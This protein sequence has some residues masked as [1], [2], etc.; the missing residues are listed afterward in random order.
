MKMK[1]ITLYSLTSF[2]PPF[3]FSLALFSFFVFLGIFIEK[4]SMLS[5]YSV[6][7]ATVFSL[8]FAQTPYIT[9]MTIPIASMSGAFFSFKKLMN[10]GE[11]KA[12]LAAGWSPFSMI[13]PLLKFSMIIAVFH[14]CFSEFV[15]APSYARYNKIYR[16]DFKKKPKE[17]SYIVESPVFKN[18]NVFFLASTYNAKA[19]TFFQLSGEKY[20]EDVP[21]YAIYASS[22]VYENGIWAL[23]DG[24][25]VEY[26]DSNVV[27][28]NHFEIKKYL[29]LP[30]PSDLV[31]SE[32]DLE[33][34]DFFSLSDRILKL[35]KLGLKRKKELIS[36]WTKLSSPISSFVMILAAAVAS[37]LPLIS[38]SMLGAG[39]SLFFGFLFWNLSLTFQ[40]MAEIET[41]SPFWG[42]FAAP[43]IF[44]VISIVLLK[45]MRVF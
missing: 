4:L 36:F 32:N 19:K 40:R 45:K 24:L 3:I 41:I 21:I 44:A 23:K 22:A 16:E 28:Q 26:N 12:F 31:F 7:F 37:M 13:S 39:V 20:F 42:A 11:W 27:A 43:I 15:A 8:A 35:K 18:G 6:S 1:R 38:G 2:L 25:E 10:S 5:K 30:S 34:M 29:D 14:F 33:M 17:S 9:S